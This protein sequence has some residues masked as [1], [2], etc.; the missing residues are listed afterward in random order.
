MAITIGNLSVRNPVFVN[1]VMVAVLVIG[2]FSL[3]QLPREQFP[4]IPFYWV[5]ISVPY[6]GVSAED[7]EKN[8]T[9]EIEEE[10]ESVPDI[11]EIT[12]TTR[13]G[14]AIIRIEF[15]EGISETRFDQLFQ[16]T[17]T[18]FEKVELPDD[19]LDPV[20]E[21]FSSNDFLP[22]VEAV[23]HGTVSYNE[24]D[25]QAD[26]LR[27][28][29]LSIQGVTDVEPV[30]MREPE[31]RIA[32]DREKAEAL[33]IPLNEIAAAISRSNATIPGG[34]LTT[35][36]REYVVRT[37]GELTSARQLSGIV[38]RKLPSGEAVTIGQLATVRDTFAR[39][40]ID[41]RYN[42]ETAISLRIVKSS[43]ADAITIVEETQNIIDS[44]RPLLPSGVSIDLFNNS[45]IQIRDDLRVLVINAVSGFILVVLT[46]F[47]FLGLRNAFVCA[48]GIPLTFAITFIFMDWSG[49]TLNGTSLFA[50]VLV[51]GLIVDHAIVMVENGYRYRQTGLPADIASI[52]G[53]DEVVGPVTSATLTTIAAF[54]PLMLIPGIIGRFLRVIPIVASFALFASLLE[55]FLFI[56]SHFAHWGAAPKQKRGEGFFG[57]LTDRFRPFL[58]KIYKRRIVIGISALIIAAAILSLTV[59]IRQD[60]FRGD[61]YNWFYINIEM[62]PGTPRAET[63]KLISVYE[64]VLLPLIG[65][66]EIQAV[67]SSIGFVERED[68]FVQ[69]SNVAQIQID[70]V[71]TGQR[72]RSIPDIMQGLQKITSSIAGPFDVRYQMVEGG[73]PVEPPVSFRLFGNDYEDLTAVTERYKDMLRNYNGLY[74]IQDDLERGKPELQVLVNPERALQLGLGVSDIGNYIRSAV[75][76]ITATV[77]YR[78]NENIDVVVT[79]DPSEQTDVSAVTSLRFPVRDSLAVPFSSVARAVQDQGIAAIKRVDGRRQIQISAEAYPDANSVK[80]MNDIVDR[81]NRELQPEFPDLTLET[82][83]EFSEF[84]NLLNQIAQLFLIGIF[85]MYL[86]LG[87]QFKSY[88][89]PVLIFFTIPAALAGVVLFLILSGN[90]FTS[91]IMYAGVALAGIAVN[92]SIVLIS[93]INDRIKTGKPVQ[94]SILEGTSVRLRP[95]VLT[96]VTTIAGLLPMALGIGGRSPVWG[97][98][99]ATIIF[100]LIFSTTST[101]LL[102]PCWYGIFKNVSDR[103]HS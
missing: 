10:L 27:D 25:R 55:A 98:M 95:I 68:E 78:E 9:S 89:Q 32:V 30:G 33:G 36:S 87:T 62:P 11:K 8:I 53:T 75:D 90:P 88:A 39:S 40:S 17:R 99:A 64:S 43:S 82:G 47:A 71:K 56:P 66:G 26:L 50:L 31:M 3:L 79:Y 44:F 14:I 84:S 21:E 58:A 91:T 46:L 80:V 77:F 20:I 7:I 67:S 2:T 45:T 28:R 83:G 35:K 24:I 51:L 22:V 73:P 69:Q 93:F 54:L 85:V 16:R 65:K 48:L 70:V 38:V 103:V 1:I 18:E 101:L 63:E 41:F 52:K 74:N 5:I 57:T 102:M 19:I 59:F 76:G 86:L 60:L 61:E 12:S 23:V 6:P 34:T 4:E 81:F 13:E 49:D 42:G 92:D 100:G 97:P 29:L 15:E 94:E 72:K 96:S 37:V